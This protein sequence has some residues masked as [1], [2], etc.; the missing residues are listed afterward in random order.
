MVGR[1]LELELVARMWERTR[2]EAGPHLATILGPAGIGKTRLID[3]LLRRVMAPGEAITVLTGRCL[4]YGQGITYWP[5]REILW[6]AA[7]I[8][9]DDTAPAAAERLRQLVGRLVAPGQ[10]DAAEAEPTTFALAMTAGLALP[11]NP[12]ERMSPE[13][14]AEE[15]ALA[16]PRLL[17]ALAARAPAVV[18]IEDLHW[19]EPPLLEM[20]ERI[21]GRS[22]GPLFM[23]ATA[24][25][26]FAEMRPGWSARPRI[27]HVSLEPLSHAESRELV[28]NLLPDV[29][30]DLHDE[31]SAAAEGNPLFTEEI[32][33]HLGD[34][35]AG[36][37]LTIPT[38]VW[39]LLAARID[40]LSHDDKAV[41]QDAAVAGRAFWAPALESMRPGRPVAESLRSLEEKGLIVARPTSSLPG[42]REF[43]FRHA[44][45]RDVAYGS[46]PIRWRAHAHALVGGWIDELA[47][48]RHEEFVD[49]L[50]YHYASAASPDAAELA[51]PLGSPDREAV[52]GKAVEALL[53]AGNAAA[54]R[55]ATQQALGFADRALALADSD[56][57]R[58]A[59]LELR[60][61]SLHAAIRSDEALASYTQA[62]AIARRQDDRETVARLRANATL[63][64]AGYSGALA[65]ESWKTTAAAFV[66]EGLAEIGEDAETF[67]AGA[68]LVGRS[69]MPRWLGSA[70]DRDR[71]R[72]DAERAIEIA[73]AIDSPYLLAYAVE[74]LSQPTVQA[75]FC[76]AAAIGQRM[77][78]VGEVLTD[79]IQAN[80]TRVLAAV[81]FVRA[82][83]ASAAE[84]AA[85]AAERQAQRLSPHRR[86][87]AAC[88]QTSALLATGKLTRLL[89]ATADV[90]E[91]IREDG[92][93]ACPFG[94]TALAGHALALFEA[95]EGAAA[96]A[97][98]G[99]L[100]SASQGAEGPALLYR[101]AEIV[102]P[103]VSLDATRARLERIAPSRE[104]VP[105]IY[106]LRAA[107]QLHALSGDTDRLADLIAEARALAGPACAPVLTCIADWAEA[108][109][110]ARAGIP[111]RSLDNVTRIAS[112]LQA[113]ADAYTGAR[114]L[115]DFLPLL[116]GSNG[117]S[118]AAGV[119]ER[120]ETMGA[121]ASAQEAHRICDA[122]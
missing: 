101:A 35:D 103:V 28:S 104:T 12:L 34:S 11:G 108:V 15:V 118:A 25:P 65:G 18:V 32:V 9:L 46:I 100:D 76:E 21:L 33:R 77:L 6:A 23:I 58:L 57:E 71:T 107:L 64:C 59:G 49:L 52:R 91:L 13:S 110:L 84:Q 2:A 102:R 119:A 113:H 41:L 82:G 72:R 31:V 114:L 62:L 17:S 10:I 22:G 29:S 44:L 75:G 112:E 86:I 87:H 56:T 79:R 111:G 67:E 3:E 61:R 26:E 78:E 38:T 99:H 73:E 27:S 93:R 81:A 88:G 63:L 117:R 115:T 69:R 5:L 40:A 97:A 37:K 50:A 83:R 45:I 60:A 4:P 70:P 105:R 95:G 90:P 98:I 14:V 121:R 116:E 51:W 1:G 120:L 66:T 24:R 8:P 48:D 96:E 54:R 19:A 122:G 53:A 74:A 92:G 106:E 20:I 36:S 80:E 47:G 55:Y 109:E 16:W 7:G 89:E 39:G 43:W 85:D 42:Q 94:A 68:L 30:P